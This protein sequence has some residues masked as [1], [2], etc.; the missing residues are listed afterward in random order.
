MNSI[1]SLIKEIILDS[2]VRTVDEIKRA[3]LDA[4]LERK[5][6]FLILPSQDIPGSTVSISCKDYEIAKRLYLNNGIVASIKHFRDNATC[7]GSKLGL[8]G[9]KWLCERMFISINSPS[10]PDYNNSPGHPDNRE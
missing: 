4:I 6:S 8:V 7:S 5:E 10:H 2:T 3:L 1:I 9:A